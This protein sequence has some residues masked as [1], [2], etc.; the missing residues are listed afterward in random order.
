MRNFFEWFASD[1]KNKQKPWL[2]LGKG[3]TYS[4][5]E[6][7]DLSQF[8]ILALNHVVRDQK[9]R[10]SHA[11]DFDVVE[12]CIDT[13]IENAEFLVVPFYP[14]INN[15]PSQHSI[16]E[17]IKE[18]E[19]LLGLSNSGRLLWYYKSPFDVGTKEALEKRTRQLM[20]EE[21]ENGFPIVPVHYFSAEAGVNLLAMAG[22]TKI[23]TLGIDGG[24]SYSN[25]F[26]DIKDK[27]L[28][29]NGQKT[30]S[31]QFRCIAQTIINKNM[32]Y[33]PL[34]L[35]TPI[36]I[37]VGSM[38]E[39]MVST[40]VLEYSIKKHCSMSV[41]V[42]PLFKSGIEVP[43]PKDPANRPRT[44]FSFQRFFI[45]QLKNFKGRAIYMDSDMHVFAD[46]KE[47]WSRDMGDADVLAAYEADGTGRK[48]QFAVM[49]MDCEKLK[50]SV[51]DIVKKLDTGEL[52]YETLMFN[53]AM[54]K[55]VDPVVE[56]EWNSLEYYEE[57]KTCN[58]HYTDMNS[59]PWLTFDNK[60]TTL[61]V[62]ELAEAIDNNFILIDYVKQHVRQ[63]SVRPSLLFQL[64]YRAYNSVDISKMA[65]RMDNYFVPPHRQAGT[66]FSKKSISKLVC[67][68]A[69]LVY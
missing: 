61:W 5:K 16:E 68:L 48:P 54:A 41:D 21:L 47:L 11:I 30:F 12:S 10:L 46:I 20:L 57:G 52:T 29:A 31:L 23:R 13:I 67:L 38:E 33:A 45:P 18:N 60:Y 9:V 35:E 69:S 24:T 65:R 32:D 26:D 4:L 42:F 43:M 15:S 44:P 53:M 64:K 51:V 50:W 27:T 55:K 56:R 8:N 66:S 2:I 28:L 1:T 39:Q 34:N 62:K 17:L 49:L 14:H 63:S 40:K 36:R 22:I 7:Y 37:F 25:K 58:L 19:K 6:Q 3:P 59:Q